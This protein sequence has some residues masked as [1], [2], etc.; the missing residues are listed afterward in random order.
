MGLRLTALGL[1]PLREWYFLGIRQAGVREIHLH[2]IHR[3]ASPD[4]GSTS[5]LGRLGR[6]ACRCGALLL[7]S[8]HADPKVMAGAAP[9]FALRRVSQTPLRRVADQP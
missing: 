3:E 2:E 5:R 1:V 6:Y 9:I 4:K 8:G 7:D